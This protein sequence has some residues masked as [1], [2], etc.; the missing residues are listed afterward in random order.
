MRKEKFR[1]FWAE[2]VNSWYQTTTI[3]TSDG[4]THVRQLCRVKNDYS[5]IVFDTYDHIKAITKESYFKN[6]WNPDEPNRL[7]LSRY[8]RAAVLTYAVIKTEPLL[9]T[10]SQNDCKIDIYFLKQRLAFY[11]A[12]GSILQD[13]P[14]E[15]IDAALYKGETI[16]DFSTLGKVDYIE[17]DDDFLMSVYKDLLYAEVYDNYNILTMANVYG[18]LTERAS[19]LGNMTPQRDDQSHSS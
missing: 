14:K 2:W 16:F 5:G 7:H 11:L 10:A 19:I 15:T 18:L 3:L 13:Y 6:K 8:K 9:Y 4:K 12:L 17:G 1:E